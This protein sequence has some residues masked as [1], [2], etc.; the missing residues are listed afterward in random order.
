[1]SKKVSKKRNC[2]DCDS[3]MSIG[4]G[5]HFCDEIGEVVLEDYA[6]SEHFCGC[7]K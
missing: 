3:C 6:P 2:L 5:D 1:M 4:E 7:N